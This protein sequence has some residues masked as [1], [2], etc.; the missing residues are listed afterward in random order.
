MIVD[1][2]SNG[3]TRVGPHELGWR[4]SLRRKHW[5]QVTRSH[6]GWDCEIFRADQVTMC[7]IRVADGT[8]ISL[9]DAKDDVDHWNDNYNE[10][11]IVVR[12]HPNAATWSTECRVHGVVVVPFRSF[13]E[14][15]EDVLFNHGSCEAAWQRGE[16]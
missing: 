8:D 10:H 14:A 11:A 4:K 9:A 5:A 3:W 15:L 13:D 16:R 6:M 1:T 12:H 7:A 2:A